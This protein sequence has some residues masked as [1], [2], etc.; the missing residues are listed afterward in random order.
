MVIN[1]NYKFIF[2]HVPKVAGSSLTH[3]LRS[4]PGDNRFLLAKTKHETLQEFCSMHECRFS[5]KGKE[6]SKE[7]SSYFRFGFVRNP[8]SRM[9]S[10]YRY[11]DES[12][13]RK[14]IDTIKS[15]KNF[16][17]LSEAGEKWINKLHSMRSQLDFFVDGNNTINVDFLGH[18]E[19]L[20]E[21]FNYVSKLLLLP[22][23]LSLPRKNSSSSSTANYIDFYDDEMISIVQRRFA[24]E[25]D[26]FG[27]KFNSPFP[28]NR[29]SGAVAP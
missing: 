1:D 16:L 3:V 26:L 25:I 11:L 10:L 20:K 18:Y 15:F 17:V 27:Y 4:L 23:Y 21:D 5:G 29:F 12:R 8:W 7:I 2:V 22:E 6:P 14:E 9:Y 19:F 13:P 28:T 24:Y